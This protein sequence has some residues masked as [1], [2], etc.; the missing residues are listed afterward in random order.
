[1]LIYDSIIRRL[2]VDKMH[3]SGEVV[4]IHLSLSDSVP[5][6]R[7]NMQWRLYRAYSSVVQ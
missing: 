1:M 4:S 6:Y 3:C 2:S 5:L 7:Q